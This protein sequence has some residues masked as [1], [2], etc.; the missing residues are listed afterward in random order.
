MRAL[1]DQLPQVADAARLGVVF[2][3]EAAQPDAGVQVEVHQPGIEDD[4]ADILE[5]Y[6]HAIGASFRDGG[7]ERGL[8]L[9]AIIDRRIEAVFLGEARAFGGAARDADRAAAVDL[10]ELAD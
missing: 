1:D 5:D 6:V 10:G 9:T 8:I 3:D 4:P 7:S 2:A